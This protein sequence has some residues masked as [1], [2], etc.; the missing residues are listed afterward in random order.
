MKLLVIFLGTIIGIIA[1]LF[2]L[3]LIIWCKIKLSVKKLG[4]DK[5]SLR[6]MLDEIRQGVHMANN[7]PKHISGMTK[8]I[9]PNIERDFPTFNES[10]LYNMTE[11]GLRTIF[12]TLENKELNN[13]LPLL[14]DQ[15]KNVIEDYKSSK[16][17]VRYDDVNFH[18]FSLKRYYKKNGVATIEVQTSLEYYYKK[19]KNNK[20]ISDF[21]KLK[22]QTRYTVDFI[23]V[24]DITQ[25]KDY[26]RVIG[27][28]CPN[29]GAPHLE[30]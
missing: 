25:I 27:I 20:V 6:S 28:H 23:Y 12:N 17:N 14:H 4:M 3:L 21:S 8:L 13:D 9:K 1:F 19:E 26:T 16:I 11:T 5:V 15:L 18:R 24:Y 2:I 22:K 29:C 30:E 7:E 10:E